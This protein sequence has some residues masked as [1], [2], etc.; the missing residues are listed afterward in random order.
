MTEK[1]QSEGRIQDEIMIALGRRPDCVVWRNTVGVYKEGPRVIR[2]GLAVGS[3]DLIV[4]V[5]GKFVALEVKKPGGR[6]SEHQKLWATHVERAGGVYA[7]VRS[8]QEAEHAIERAIH[9]R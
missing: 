2:Y 4:C 1:T 7:V 8:V 6:Q 5:Q 3:A 9:G